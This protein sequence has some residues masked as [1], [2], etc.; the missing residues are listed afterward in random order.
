VVTSSVTETATATAKIAPASSAVGAT[1]TAAANMRDGGDSAD[2]E[3][4][5]R[6]KSTV[7]SVQRGDLLVVGLGSVLC[8]VVL[9]LRRQLEAIEVALMSFVDA[10][11]NVR[12]VIPI[13][14]ARLGSVAANLVRRQFFDEPDL[15]VSV[16]L[17]IRE[18]GIGEHRLGLANGLRLRSF[19][20]A[21]YG[22][23]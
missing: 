23:A 8:S 4:R 3:N 14:R 1:A 19:I 20:T 21:V 16:E 2:P 11:A 17:D 6:E 9:M 15:I 12:V 5:R 13:D 7:Q 18:A 10:C 22:T